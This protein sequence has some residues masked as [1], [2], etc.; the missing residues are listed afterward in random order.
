MTG[1]FPLSKLT[2]FFGLFIVISSAFMRQLMNFTKANIGDSGFAVLISS[3]LIISALAFLVFVIKKRLSRRRTFLL[4]G[5][6]V[7]GLFLIS[8]IEIAEEKIHLLEFAVLGWL[9]LR[10][11]FFI[12]KR[13]KGFILALVFTLTIGI[14]DEGFQ[15]ILPY[16]YFQSWDILLNN[17]GGLWG[18]ILFLVFRST[19]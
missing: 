7:A 12:G 9:A 6:V 10:D 11:S 2:L 14:L 18:I 5:I 16:R 3:T 8:K 13:F 1:Y 19:K 17:L 4:A 15:A